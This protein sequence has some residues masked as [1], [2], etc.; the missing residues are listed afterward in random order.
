MCSRLMRIG[1][2]VIVIV[3]LAGNLA[4][5]VESTNNLQTMNSQ[6]ENPQHKNPQKCEGSK[7]DECNG[8]CV[9]FKNDDRNCGSCGNACDNDKVCHNGK[10]ECHGSKPDECSGKCVN[11]KSDKQNCGDCGKVCSQDEVC[12]NGKCVSGNNNKKST[13]TDGKKNGL[14]T[15]I[16]CGGPTCPPCTY[17]KN[18]K[19]ST[20]CSSGVCAIGYCQAPSCIDGVKN[21]NETGVDCGGTCPPCKKKPISGIGNITVPPGQVYNPPGPAAPTYKFVID[22]CNV[23]D[24]RS[25]DSDIDWASI[26]VSVSNAIAK[27]TPKSKYAGEFVSA[28]YLIDL[29]VGPIPI[30]NDPNIPVTIAFL[31]VNSATDNSGILNIMN[32]GTEALINSYSGSGSALAFA[33]NYLGGILDSYCDGTV[34]ADRIVTNGQTI[35]QWTANGPH[36]VTTRYPGTDSSIGCGSN[37]D[38]EV[39]WHVERVS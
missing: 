33:D 26:G 34:A 10:C 21:G 19:N 15:D 29:E 3:L 31:M 1:L 32:A 23:I 9:N 13:C 7:P 4:V 25:P 37:S 5:C 6:T 39:T 2:V 12:H 38:Y 8:K 18:C 36:S 14:E 24:L 28:S 27:G 22:K 11:L 17:G 20:D 16:D 35:A 30:P